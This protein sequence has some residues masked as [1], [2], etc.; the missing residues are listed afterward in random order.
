[1]KDV[2]GTLIRK[3][4]R[5]RLIVSIDILHQGAAVDINADDV[6]PI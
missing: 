5:A 2:E 1:L 6:E 4:P 3:E